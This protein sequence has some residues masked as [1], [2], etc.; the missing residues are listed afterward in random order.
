LAAAFGKELGD[1]QYLDA[2]GKGS[3]KLW[4]IV[5]EGASASR[6]GGED[7]PDAAMGDGFNVLFC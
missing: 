4:I 1:V 5:F 3:V 7:C 6:A 2:A